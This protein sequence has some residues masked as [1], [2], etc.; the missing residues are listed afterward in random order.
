MRFNNVYNLHCR[1]YFIHNSKG[2]TRHRI[3]GPAMEWTD[4]V[5]GYY[6]DGISCSKEEFDEIQSKDKKETCWFI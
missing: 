2:I 1:S 5:I 3:E 4:G 6:I